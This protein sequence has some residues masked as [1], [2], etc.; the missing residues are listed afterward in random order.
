[1]RH[2]PYC[3]GRAIISNSYAPIQ[4]FADSARRR[5]RDVRIRSFTA[6]LLSR[7]DVPFAI[8]FQAD[9]SSEDSS[10]HDVI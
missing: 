8:V 5:R 7:G 1:M 10:D 3:S 4:S 2:V 9:P 6:V